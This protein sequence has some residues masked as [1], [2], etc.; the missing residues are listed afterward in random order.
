MFVGQHVGMSDVTLFWCV[1]LRERQC[2][3]LFHVPLIET[4]FD[5]RLTVMGLN[6]D[7]IHR[8]SGLK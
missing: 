6:L 5:A 4:G 1:C 3:S 2:G 8:V 7:L